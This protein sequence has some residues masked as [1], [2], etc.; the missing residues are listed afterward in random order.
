MGFGSEPPTPRTRPTSL[1]LSRPNPIGARPLEDAAAGAFDVLFALRPSRLHV[2]RLDDLK[3]HAVVGLGPVGTKCL[4]WSCQLGDNI[5]YLSG[6]SNRV[7]LVEKDH[8][9][10]F[11]CFSLANFTHQAWIY[12]HCC[13]GSFNSKFAKG[14]D[15]RSHSANYA[16]AIAR[17]KVT[18]EHESTSSKFKLRHY[19]PS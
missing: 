16:R 11:A 3:K 5:F 2:A 1:E 6:N 17:L 12:C 13:V 15:H 19:P 8:A 4:L 7:V 10:I 9:R 18:R 14:V